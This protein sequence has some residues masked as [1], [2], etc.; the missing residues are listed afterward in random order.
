MS[1]LIP[2]L[3]VSLIVPFLVAAAVSIAFAAILWA[4]LAVGRSTIG[5]FRRPVSR[6]PRTAASA[7]GLER[8][9]GS[10]DDRAQEHEPTLLAAE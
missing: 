2:R 6:S 1:R 8:V 10:V 9:R 3:A 7:D 4:S 5:L